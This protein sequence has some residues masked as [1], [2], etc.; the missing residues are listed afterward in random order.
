MLLAATVFGHGGRQGLHGHSEQSSST[1]VRSKRER[2]V[3]LH[4]VPSF[5]TNWMFPPA[6]GEQITDSDDTP[7]APET[8]DVG[9]AA[10]SLANSE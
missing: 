6:N 7:L 3:Q 2:S 9:D 10:T 1:V 5:T 4:L 8:L